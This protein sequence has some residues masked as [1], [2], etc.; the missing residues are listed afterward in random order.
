MTLER[1]DQ[2]IEAIL[3]VLDKM[4]G[5]PCREPILSA[6]LAKLVPPPLL[7]SE[8]NAAL[9]HAEARRWILGQRPNL[10]SVLWTLT[11]KG[12]AVLLECRR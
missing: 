8:F 4:D 1:R 12:K 9:R 5:E 10:G 7:V 2:I 3:G 6:S 11:A